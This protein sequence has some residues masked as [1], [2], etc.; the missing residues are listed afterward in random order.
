[1][2]EVINGNEVQNVV[3]FSA[4]KGIGENSA[5]QVFEQM[6][7]QQIRYGE[8]GAKVKVDVMA[9]QEKNARG[10]TTEIETAFKP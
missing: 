6:H 4:N 8:E 5:Y 10:V 1:M 3:I 9:R 2:V 7:E